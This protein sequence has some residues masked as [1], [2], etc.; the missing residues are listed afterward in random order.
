[1]LCT[2]CLCDR[3]GGGDQ[4]LEKLVECSWLDLKLLPCQVGGW[5]MGRNALCVGGR[6]LQLPAN[7]LCPNVIVSSVDGRCS[8]SLLYHCVIR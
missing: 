4:G 5:G 1:M 7:V 3:R 8:V 6:C 2:L